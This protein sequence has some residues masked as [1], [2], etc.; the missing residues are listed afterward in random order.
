MEAV[1]KFGS[2]PWAM[3]RHAV[4]YLKVASEEIMSI[5]A[6]RS[7]TLSSVYA[8]LGAKVKSM[9]SITGKKR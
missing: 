9:T 5:D 4:A 3:K 7:F 1:S 6:T 2:N 8:P